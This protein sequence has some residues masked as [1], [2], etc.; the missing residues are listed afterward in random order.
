[1]LAMFFTFLYYAVP[2]APVSRRSALIGGVFAA[3]A[4]TAMQKVFEF[5]LASSAILKSVTARLRRFRYFSS[6]ST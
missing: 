6:G 2:N 1:M 5:Y 4:F 3:L